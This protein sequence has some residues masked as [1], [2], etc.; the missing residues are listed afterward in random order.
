M[1]VAHHRGTPPWHTHRGAHKHSLTALALTHTQ[2]ALIVTADA[3]GLTADDVKVQVTDGNM[4][5]ISGERHNEHEEK[6]DRFHRIERSYGKFMRRFPLPDTV[7]G[8]KVTASVDHGVVHVSIPKKTATEGPR[9]MDV[10]VSTKT[11]R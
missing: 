8:G 10:K 9:V 1:T 2:D 5:T 7:D 4:L 6:T 3:P 11:G